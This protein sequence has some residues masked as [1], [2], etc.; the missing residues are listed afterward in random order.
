MKKI[1]LVCS[2][3]MSTSLMVSKMKKYAIENNFD[4]KIEAVAIDA[5]DRVIENE[6][7][8]V[9]LFGPQVRF[10][11]DKFKIKY[12]NLKMDVI[13]MQDYGL[14]NGENVFKQALKLNG[15]D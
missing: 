5:A 11:L 13:P 9:V 2:A 14:M 1:L 7:I 3:G 4:T 12:P 6:K 8:E 15:E 10:V